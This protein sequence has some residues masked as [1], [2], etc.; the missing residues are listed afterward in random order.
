MSSPG[1]Y[2]GKD[3][4][5]VLSLVYPVLIDFDK[6]ISKYPNITRYVGGASTDLASNLQLDERFGSAGWAVDRE[7]FYG[8]PFVA[9]TH[10]LISTGRPS[11]KKRKDECV[12]EL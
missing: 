6:T 8:T 5:W 12:Y 2:A 9:L 10:V 7:S 11:T 1:K 4:G 3:N